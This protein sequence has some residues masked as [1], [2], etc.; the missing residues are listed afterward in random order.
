[1]SRVD[2]SDVGHTLDLQEQF[3]TADLRSQD[4]DAAGVG[5]AGL[6]PKTHL[7]RDVV[8]RCV[9]PEMHQSGERLLD[10]RG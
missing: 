3:R 2:D 4:L 6:E 1:M 8:G 7:T 9:R 5:G 10:T